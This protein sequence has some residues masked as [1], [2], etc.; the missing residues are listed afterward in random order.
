MKSY[1]V[2]FARVSASVLVC[3]VACSEPAQ[4]PVDAGYMPHL[5]VVTL[6][7]TRADR[8]G[9]YGYDEPTSPNL[10]RLAR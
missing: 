1:L 2:W 8:L 7:T 10:D 5:L 3:I 9:C 4:T 6:D